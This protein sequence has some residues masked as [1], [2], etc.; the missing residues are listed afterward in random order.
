VA[1]AGDSTPLGPSGFTVSQGSEVFV[2]SDAL[3]AQLE[4]LSRFGDTI[5]LLASELVGLIDQANLAFANAT[6]IPPRAVEA[7]RT[8][9][10]SLRLLRAARDRAVAIHGAL[11]RSLEVYARTEDV[12]AALLHR[13][14]EE[15]AWSL[16]LATRVFALP[17]AFGAGEA[18]LAAY[19]LT[20]GR[21][22]EVGGS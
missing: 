6:N 17:L 9:E 14:G 21:P 5:P 16:G 22:A 20:G 12:E 11:T 10:A 18:V 13:V 1:E 8:M 3:L 2:E 19:L 4:R 15:V 7:R